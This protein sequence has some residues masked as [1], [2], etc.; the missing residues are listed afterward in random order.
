MQVA[1]GLEAAHE[2][3]IIHRDIKPANIFLT[4]KGTA[5][6][7]DFGLAKLAVE[8]PDAGL[9]RGFSPA[10]ASPLPLSS[11]PQEAGVAA[12]A[13]GSAVDAMYERADPSTSG[14][15][16]RE[17]AAEAAPLRPPTP[18]EHTLTRTGM[19]MGTAGYMSPE[20][21]RGEKLDARTDLF[22]FGLVLYEMA[23]GQRAFTGETA[24]ILKDAILNNSP[25]PVHEVNSTMPVKLE[26]VI[27][28]ALEKDRM[29]RYQSATEMR[30]DLDQI[31]PQ[32]KRRAFRRHW[33]L[34]TSAAIVLALAAGAIYWRFQQ[35]VNLTDQDTVVLANFANLTGEPLFD[36][37]LQTALAVS[38][39]QSPFL[40]VLSGEKVR[41]TLKLMKHSS[42]EPMTREVALEVCRKT[43]SRAL[44]GGSIT[45]S[46]NQF[47]IKLDAVDC[48]TGRSFASSEAEAANRN[49]VIRAVGQAATQLRGKVSEPPDL[50]AQFNQPP[51][52][53]LTSSLQALQAFS[54]ANKTESDPAALV[55]LKQAIELDSNFTLAYL[56]LAQRYHDLLQPKLS[57]EYGKK[58]Y[59]LR[60]RVNARQRF[61]VEVFYHLNVTG[62]L[63]RALQTWAQY[64]Q[65]YPRAPAS[66]STSY[67]QR[68]LGLHDKAA[69]T[70]EAVLQYSPNLA[71]PVVNLMDAYMAL[72]KPDQAKTV[73]DQARARDLDTSL[74]R[75]SRYLLAFMQGDD[76]AMQ[77]QV[78][79]GK[80]KPG[81]EDMLLSY[82][83]NT[84][85]YWGRLG[86]ARQLSQQAVT[87]PGQSTFPEATGGLIANE[88]LR[89]AEMGNAAR[90]RALT[91]KALSLTEGRN[92]EVIAAL[93]LARAGDSAA[94]EK[95][96]D[97]LNQDA[98][99]DT[100]IQGYWLP[101]I[102]ATIA[103]NRD[104]PE[105]ALAMLQDAFKY[106]LGSPIE[107]I[108]HNGPMYPAY[109]ARP[110]ISKDRPCTASD[111]RVPEDDQP[112]RDH[113]EFRA[114][115]AGASAARSRPGDDGR[116]DCRAQ[117]VSGF[118]HPLERRRSRHP[119]L[120]AGQGRIRETAV[121]GSG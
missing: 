98:P 6:I 67:M 102:R 45:D 53:A 32:T 35:S 8:A 26:Q 78:A 62:D 46:G 103:L 106:E 13:E 64:F 87:S 68:V 88:A 111:R 100:M 2:Q 10:S 33:M 44:V 77:E 36:D 71:N 49:G 115:S 24:A 3:G 83:S 120:P 70:A 55:S 99:Q 109:R 5:K 119:H 16:C 114:G 51:E 80:G 105:Q 25:A 57:T 97:K 60:D 34:W 43:N 1:D 75:Y 72:E 84:E 7:L 116:Q 18:V 79:W 48:R 63:E 22:S 85:A 37:S 27:G 4:K 38:L 42:S 20:Q 90:A 58:A 76:A 30:A 108:T 59:E 15:P 101:T 93:T 107:F 47:R 11:R 40:D 112:S 17:G 66:N 56:S 74:L 81:V 73:F 9:E 121:K 95:L 89:E 41:A 104:H 113:A 65:A 31:A 12:G 118:P 92:T 19:A 21:V 117:V 29:R 52:K 94:A 28:R 50:I 14:P 91:A 61:S 54:R 23:T 69:V 86:K 82:Q 96:A 110:G 39:Q